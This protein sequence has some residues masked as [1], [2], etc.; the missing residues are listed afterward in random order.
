MAAGAGRRNVTPQGTYP[1]ELAH[2]AAAHIANN[3]SIGSI[4]S[5]HSKPGPRSVPTTSLLAGFSGLPLNGG[6]CQVLDVAETSARRA[7]VSMENPNLKLA[8]APDH[9]DTR[10]R[11]GF[12]LWDAGQ[13]S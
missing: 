11:V 6:M 1:K 2:P 9:L 10:G 13:V 7:R 8:G 3:H 12:S 5:I 4:N